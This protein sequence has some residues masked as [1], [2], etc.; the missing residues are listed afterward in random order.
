[1]QILSTMALL[2]STFI[3]STLAHY[4][5]SQDYTGRAFYDGFDFFTDA[6]PTNGHVKFVDKEQ[7]NSS[8]IAGL[9]S[10]GFANNAVYLGMDAVND[11]PQGR[12]SIRVQSSKAFNHGLIIADIAHMPGGVCSTWPAFWMVGPNWPAGGEIDIVEGVNEQTSNKMTLHTGSGVAISKN[13]SFSGELVTP[14]CDIN[15]PGQ[16]K[17]AGCLILDSDNATYGKGFNQNGGGVYATE[18]TSAAIKIWFFPRSAIPADVASGNPEPSEAWGAPRAAFAGDFKVDEHFK[19]LNIV[20]DTTFC[21]DWAGKVW[22]N[23][24]CAV[25]APTC[26]EYVTQNRAAFRDTFWAINSL[27]V[28]DTDDQPRLRTRS[29]GAVLPTLP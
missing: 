2:V 20:F 8:G 4:T 29:G 19:D 28:F 6:D 5:I 27:K 18:W 3:S 15:A 24:S 1:M 25:L 10:G 23:S 16:D 21:G 7:A 11:A 9:M 12:K 17:N 22:A 14:N 13:Q 26:E